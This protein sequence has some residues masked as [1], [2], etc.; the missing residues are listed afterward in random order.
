M[1]NPRLL[2]VP[3]LTE[4]EW[5]IK[6]QLEEWADVASYDAPGV[7]AEPPAE[8]FGSQ[9]VARRG[10]AELQRCGWDRCVVVADEFGVAAAANLVAAAPDVV[11]AMAIGHARLSNSLEGERAP[12]NR[13]VYAGLATLMRTDTR[14]FVRQFFRLT[15]GE[16]MVGGYGE[17]MVDAYLERVPVEELLA[18]WET[19]PEEGAHIG[20]QLRGLGVPILLAR[21]KGCLLYTEEGFEDAVNALPNAQ[22]VSVDDKPS[23]SEEFARLLETFC[24]EQVPLSA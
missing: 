17:D 22:T 4:L 20:Y 16:T 9:A 2:L 7:G 3:Q 6:Q 11:Q 14:T 8:Q 23:T 21:H 1:A 15:G 18:F 10:L 19:R 12:L 5:P 13:E 24:R